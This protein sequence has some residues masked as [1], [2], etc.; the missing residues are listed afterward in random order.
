M[1]VRKYWVEIALLPP[2]IVL[3][4]FQGYKTFSPKNYG[5]DEIRQSQQEN[6]ET[7]KGLE[8]RAL[9]IKGDISNLEE[10]IPY[11]F[12]KVIGEN[13]SIHMPPGDLVRYLDGETDLS[14]LK[15]RK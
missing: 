15:A 3:A 9:G 7:L 4:L 5:L 12:G 2:L 6:I 10:S 8:E 11:H 14:R 13:A 1:N